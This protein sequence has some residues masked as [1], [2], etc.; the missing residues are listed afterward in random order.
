MPYAF[1]NL[2]GEIKSTFLKPNPLVRLKPDERMVKYDPPEVDLDYYTVTPI[3]PVTGKFVEFTV[4][5]KPEAL[6]KRIA[7][8][9]AR[10]DSDV[11][12][13]YTLVVGN[14]EPEYRQAEA[15]ALAFQQ[16]GFQGP[17]PSMV[18][19]YA[20]ADNLSAQQSAQ[21]ILAKAESW[22]QASAAIRTARLAAKSQV[23]SG[24]L[25]GFLVTWPQFLQNI[26][27]ALG[28]TL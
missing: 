23:R 25:A 19:D 20:T 16:A 11:D 10:I 2:Q 5:E 6:N 21:S 26:S 1:V 15:E 14:R 28:V 7:N 4:T 13:I 24:D 8:Y 9:V 22:R 12:R 27:T 17:V 3:T 18:Q